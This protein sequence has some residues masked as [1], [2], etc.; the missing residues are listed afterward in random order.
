MLAQ[1]KKIFRR[2][3]SLSQILILFSFLLGLSFIFIVPPFQ[4][5]DEPTHFSKAISM[6]SGTIICTKNNNG[7]FQS[8]IPKYLS[9]FPTQMLTEHIASGRQ[10]VFPVSLYRKFL[11]GTG[12]DR[13]LVNEPSSCS[14]PFMLYLPLAI[15]LAIPVNLGVNPLFIFYLGRLTNFFVA[16]ALFLVA[17]KII[18][19]KLRLLP[20]FILSLPI[21]LLQLSSFSKDALHIS[22]GVLSF[23]LLLSFFEKKHIHPREILLFLLS[24]AITVL[25]RPQYI[26]FLFF[27]LLIPYK[28]VTRS[29]LFSKMTS[30]I[31]IFGILFAIGLFLSKEVYSAKATSLGE[32][33]PTSY[34]YPE[35]QMLFIQENWLKIPGVISETME[36]NSI[37]YLEG[38]IGLLGWL[39]YSV[40]W[41]VY[42]FYIL[43]GAYVFLRIE[44]E[45]PTFNFLQF[46]IT[47]CILFGTFLGILFSFY[48]YASP[49]ASQTVLGVQGRYFLVLIPGIFLSFAY[50]KRMLERRLFILLLIIIFVAVFFVT[51]Y[52]YFDSSHHAYRDITSF[53]IIQSEHA[54][55][56]EQPFVQQ[57]RVQKEKKL[58]G[59]SIFVFKQKSE[60]FAPYQLEVL[61]QSCTQ[62][63]RKVVVDTKNLQTDNWNDLL[64]A[65][66]KDADEVC[67]KLAPYKM[68]VTQKESLKVA[69]DEFAKVL[70]IPVYLN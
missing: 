12:F 54:L 1:F 11:F 52:R 48:L 57:L 34:V 68:S 44:K 4:K 65:P 10:V 29:R 30:F 13:S 39:E 21:V 19:K 2:E 62:T 33:S 7:V 15:I 53:P 50:L 59:V 58:R 55:F 40:P 63:L 18:P 35:V 67:V 32:A 43:L 6:A 49:V 51:I 27:S 16:F 23:C 24:L 8:R 5:P 14:L 41:Y 45:F 66:L 28:K 31:F 20:V 25:A 47:A 70:L 69:Q 36:R 64:F 9:E 42:L 38:S 61:D 22:C 37:Y 60:G 17:Y 3:F 26:L 56:V 46:C